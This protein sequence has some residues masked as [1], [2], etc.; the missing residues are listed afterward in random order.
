MLSVHTVPTFDDRNLLRSALFRGLR[1]GSRDEMDCYDG[2]S[3]F[4]WTDSRSRTR[5]CLGL[6]LGHA[7]GKDFYFR[8]ASGDQPSTGQGNCLPLQLLA[9]MSPAD[10]PVPFLQREA[11]LWTRFLFGGSACP[12]LS[13]AARPALNEEEQRRFT[14]LRR[15]LFTYYRAKTAPVNTYDDLIKVFTKTLDPILMSDYLTKKSVNPPPKGVVLIEPEKLDH[16]PAP[17]KAMPEDPEGLNG[18]L[19]LSAEQEIACLATF[20]RLGVHRVGDTLLVYL[21]SYVEDVLYSGNITPW[22]PSYEARASHLIDG[23]EARYQASKFLQTV[24]EAETDTVSESKW[25]YLGFPV[26]YNRDEIICLHV[27]SKLP[28]IETPRPLDTLVRAPQV[29]AE[30]L[31]KAKDTV[32]EQTR[33]LTTGISAGKLTEMSMFAV[34]IPEAQQS[35]FTDTHLRLVWPYGGVFV[36]PNVFRAMSTEELRKRFEDR[37][38]QQCDDNNQGIA[39]RVRDPKDL[40]KAVSMKYDQSEYVHLSVILELYT[41]LPEHVREFLRDNFAQSREDFL[42][43]LSKPLVAEDRLQGQKIRRKLKFSLSEDRLLWDS[44]VG[45]GSKDYWASVHAKM[46]HHALYSVRKRASL[47]ALCKAKGMRVEDCQFTKRIYD[48]IPDLKD[49]YLTVMG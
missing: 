43:E 39:V 22:C 35:W 9:A 23:R 19:C 5:P 32:A 26:R 27:P 4:Q 29:I 31:E 40:W 16:P 42:M 30:N 44:T 47:L 12:N 2:V 8:G 36:S 46:P 20:Q 38:R 45:Y 48:A 1:Q 21:P 7:T 41:E 24:L 14:T 15:R 28:V 10:C 34:G 6:D 18:V 13:Y 17:Y 49:H 3:K 25:N 11:W 33:L 37:H